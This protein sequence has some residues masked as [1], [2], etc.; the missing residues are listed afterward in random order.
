LPGIVAGIGGADMTPPKGSDVNSVIAPPGT[1]KITW[2]TDEKSNDIFSYIDVASTGAG[3][4][5]PN[6]EGF[7]T[8]HERTIKSL[9]A[10]K[11]YQYTIISTD[12]SGNPGQKQ[13]TF[14]S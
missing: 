9:P 11:T 14:K 10:G 12:T 3:T 13:G 4:P 6:E 7:V 1:V 8:S 2:K 5:T